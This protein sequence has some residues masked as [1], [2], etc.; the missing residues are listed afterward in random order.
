MT[1]P[2]APPVIRTTSGRRPAVVA[3]AWIGTLAVSGL[4]VIGFVEA[5]GADPWSLR[6]LSAGR[7]RSARVAAG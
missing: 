6:W 4:P 5:M 1:S 3:V 7:R 2:T